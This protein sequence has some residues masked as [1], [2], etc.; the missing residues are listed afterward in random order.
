MNLNLLSLASGLAAHATARQQVI[1]E[2]VAH[3]DTPGYRARD[4]ADFAATLEA[5]PAFGA[6]TTRPGHIPF[7]ADPHGFEPREDAALRGGDAER[8]LGVAGGP[9]D[10]RRRGAPGARPGAR[11][12]MPSRWRSCA[13]PWPGAEERG[14]ERAEQDDGGL[15]ERHGGAGGADAAEHGEHRQRRHARLPAQDG[16]LR[17]DLRRGPATPGRWRPGRCSS[18]GASSTASTTPATRWPGRTAIYEGSNVDLV[19]EIADAREANRS[20]EANLRMFDQAR[21]DGE[22]AARP[23]PPLDEDP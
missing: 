14:H 3:A 10:A 5:G 21:A 9:D 12:S 6:R 1:S 2:N 17:G 7:G 18:T 11:A 15:G 22:L 4:I 23:A 16:V 8:Q 19:V 13:P 20:Y